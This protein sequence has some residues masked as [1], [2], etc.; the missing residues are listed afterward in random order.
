[1]TERRELREFSALALL[2][3]LIVLGLASGLGPIP[4]DAVPAI[5]RQ[6]GLSV[7]S[8]IIATPAAWAATLGR[9]V[10][11]GIGTTIA[12][13]V[14]SQV[15]VIAGSGGWL[16]FAAPALWAINTDIAVTPVQ[17]PSCYQ[18]SHSASP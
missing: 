14:A 16:P 5:G 9:S 6:F 8:I 12:I 17:L 4:A 1:M 2:L 13:L 18:S 10:L 7:F 3:A 11:A 15:S